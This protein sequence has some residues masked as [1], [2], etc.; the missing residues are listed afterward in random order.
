M[1]LLEHGLHIQLL[2]A[3]WNSTYK[4][5][6]PYESLWFIHFWDDIPSLST[7]WEASFH[8]SFPDSRPFGWPGQTYN[9]SR[10]T[11][12]G[13]KQ[14]SFD[15]RSEKISFFHN[16]RQNGQ[17]KPVGPIRQTNQ[18]NQVLMIYGMRGQPCLMSKHRPRHLTFE[19]QIRHHLNPKVNLN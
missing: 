11:P 3:H 1:S 6:H 19:L 15:T 2:K 18:S 4:S 12:F 5:L 10:I 14:A 13:P 9:P 7:L 8:M 17:T 16:A